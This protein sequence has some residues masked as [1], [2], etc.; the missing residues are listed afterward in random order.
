MLID[1]LS[2]LDYTVTDNGTTLTIEFTD[3]LGPTV[4]GTFRIRKEKG[5]AFL[6]ALSE[7]FIEVRAPFGEYAENFSAKT[8]MRDKQ[9]GT[10]ILNEE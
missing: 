4:V 6:R 8:V 3:P 10:M 9:N 7:L 2:N 1:D 5:Q